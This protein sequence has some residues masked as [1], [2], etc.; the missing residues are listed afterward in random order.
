MS[1][2]G[3]STGMRSVA[4]A[5]TLR[6]RDESKC[7]ADKNF[8]RVTRAKR[9]LRCGRKSFGGVTGSDRG[10]FGWDGRLSFSVR[11]CTVLRTYRY[12]S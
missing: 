12:L 3:G 6:R 2:S 10:R 8:A 11:T 4:A 5:A 1:G 9:N 7:V